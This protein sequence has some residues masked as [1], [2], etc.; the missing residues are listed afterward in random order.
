MRSIG[1][2]SGL[3]LVFFVGCGGAPP[4]PPAAP[5]PAPSALA[6]EPVEKADLSPVA[7]PEE[8]FVVGRLA[9][10]GRVADT[11]DKW[12]GPRTSF[13]SFLA[14]EFAGLDRAIAWDAP[15]ELAVALSK[16]GKR[17]AV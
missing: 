13:R 10:P 17:L 3:V 6:K 7:V 8:L 2:L 12:G 15:V 9:R 11:L 4:A 5:P 16:G 14:Q 1:R